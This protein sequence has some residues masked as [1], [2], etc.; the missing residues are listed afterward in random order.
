VFFY[1]AKTFWFFAQPL[2]LAI[3]LTFAGVVAGLSGRRRWAIAG[4]GLGVLVLVLS[5][6][7]SFGAML[8]APLEGRFQRP[9]GMPPHV[10]GIIVL[11]GGMEGAINLMR[12]GY[13]MNRAGDRFVEALRLARLYPDAKILISGGVGTVL[14]NGEGDADTAL[15]LF[16]DFGFPRE[17][18]MIEDKSRDTAENAR[19]SKEL[20]N[21]RPGET[22]LLITSAFHMPRSIGLFRKVGFPVVPWPSDYRTTGAEGIAVFQDNPTDLLDVTTMAVREW[23]GLAGYWLA[24]RIDILFPGP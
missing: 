3:F 4:G 19:F 23:I 17:R 7:T 6:W 21:P 10:D 9:A 8:M 2:N 15:R 12:G 22:W 14:L 1:L 5:A 18:L 13:E 16:G 11:G 24:G 20:V